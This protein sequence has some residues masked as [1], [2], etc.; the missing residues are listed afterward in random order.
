[1]KHDCD[2]LDMAGPEEYHALQAQVDI[3]S[4]CVFL[5]Q[6]LTGDCAVVSHCT[7]P[8]SVLFGVV[9]VII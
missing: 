4:V 1:M 3:V 9:R 6:S 5:P 2:V 8:V 7:G